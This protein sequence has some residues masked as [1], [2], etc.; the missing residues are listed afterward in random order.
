MAKLSGLTGDHMGREHRL[1]E[2]C[3]LGRGLEA[4]IQLMDRAVSRQHAK[5]THAGDKYLI[6]DLDSGRGTRVNGMR[7]SASKLHP[8]DEININ[9]HRFRF[10]DTQQESKHTAEYPL[11]LDQ[12]SQPALSRAEHPSS[13]VIGQETLVTPLSP[14]AGADQRRLRALTAMARSASRT[15]VENTL[16]QELVTICLDAF[17]GADRVLVARVDHD[18]QRLSAR[19]VRLRAGGENRRFHISRWAMTEVL[20]KGRPVLTSEVRKNDRGLTLDGEG[21]Q[22]QK[23]VVPIQVMGERLGLLYMDRADAST[24]A[25][26]DADLET[27]VALCRTVAL[28]MRSQELSEL[29]RARSVTDRQLEA[30]RQVQK[31]FLPRGSPSIPG[32]S[33]VTHYD[34]CQDVGGDLYDF[35]QLDANRLGVVVGDVSGKGFPAALVMAWVTSQL[36]TAVHLESSPAGVMARINQGLLE[37]RQ[38]ELFVTLFY[39]VL[40]VWNMELTFCNAGHLPPLVRRGAHGVVEAI[41][42]AAGMPVGMFPETVYEEGMISLGLGDAV[43]LVSDGVTEA[44]NKAGELFGMGRL[45]Q[46]LARQTSSP[47]DLVSDL[48]GDLRAFSAGTKQA[49]DITIVALGVGGATE[50]VRTTLPPGFSI[51]SVTPTGHPL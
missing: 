4:Q 24:E 7:I 21:D 28:A 19:L 41:E 29:A 9:G 44:Q 8:G 15:T 27:C 11:V 5:I 37:A 22:V 34:P 25:F 38:D 14:E 18:Q 48:L 49:D 46:A 39:G 50:D 6:E 1:G 43:L 12:T 16:M 47:G 35:I 17:P 42:A 23:M 32:F 45:R 36:R 31:R 20:S 51:T 13:E 26:S 3:I 40:D 33:F 10:E 30:A 2:F